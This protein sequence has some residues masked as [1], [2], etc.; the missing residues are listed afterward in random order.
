MSIKA[1]Q[2]SR[3][4]VQRILRCRANRIT[5]L[6]DYSCPI[7]SASTSSGA[8]L[9]AWAQPQEIKVEFEL[10]RDGGVDVICVFL[11]VR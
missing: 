3:S 6:P 2:P 4:F 1:T 7:P 10:R 9:V 11:A 5:G 8:R